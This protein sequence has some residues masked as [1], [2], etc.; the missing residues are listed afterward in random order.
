[1]FKESSNIGEE[2]DAETLGGAQMHS[3]ISGLSDY[4]AEDEMDALRI[5]RE[6]VSHLNWKKT[7]DAPK[8]EPLEP[9]YSQEE[10][11]LHSQQFFLSYI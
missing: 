6:V 9:V 5:C 8:K 11:R 3:E 7:G 10:L 1:M 2:S 4:L